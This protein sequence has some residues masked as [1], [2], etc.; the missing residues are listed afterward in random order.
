VKRGYAGPDESADS[1][2]VL[3]DPVW[4][5]A[6]GLAED[7]TVG[8]FTFPLACRLFLLGSLSSFGGCISP[9]GDTAEQ[10]RAHILA[11]HEAT[12]SL[13]LEARP[14][15]A[16]ELERAP[17]YATMSNIATQ[18]L[19]L[20]GGNGYGVAVRDNG[21][22]I[23]MTSNEY[24]GGPGVGS[25]TYR[26]VLLFGTPEAFDRFTAGRWLFQAEADATA[27]TED[28]GGGVQTTGNLGQ[29]IRIF[30][31]DDH[32]LQAKANLSGIRFDP[33]PELNGLP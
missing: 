12:K 13:L 5:D 7:Q 17:G 21:Q 30:H 8:S 33:D 14:D 31:F 1:W 9:P 20:G 25:T 10:R 4:A 6:G 29:P 23:F 22:Q 15:L 26:S 28:L 18:V 24:A 11:Q 3:S 27:R 16:D 32:G 19:V 2:T